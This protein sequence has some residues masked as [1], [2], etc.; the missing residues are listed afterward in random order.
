MYS[1]NWMEQT[2]VS[3]MIRI[4]RRSN[5]VAETSFFQQVM[6]VQDSTDI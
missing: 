5:V 4:K 2:T 6:T 3:T 1:L